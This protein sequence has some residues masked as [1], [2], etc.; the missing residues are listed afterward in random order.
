MDGPHDLGGKEG[1]GPINR[2]HDNGPFHEAWEGRAFAIVHT[3]GGNSNWSVDWFRHSRELIEPTDYLTRPYFDQWAQT[4]MAQMIEAGHVTLHELISGVSVADVKAEVPA[5][6]AKDIDR[7]ITTERS[8]EVEPKAPPR[9]KIGD[10]IITNRYGHSGHSRL[11]GYARGCRGVILSHH[12]AHP[13]ADAMARGE[14]VP[15]HLYTVAFAA[16]ELWPEAKGSQDKVN[17]DL[18]ESYFEHA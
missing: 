5:K 8:F 15:E 14:M 17:I 9:F 11:P 7:V 3:G 13:L 1:F 18:W 10:Q 12:G 6:E 16:E 2:E 4:V